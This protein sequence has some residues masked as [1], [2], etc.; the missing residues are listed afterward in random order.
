MVYFLPKEYKLPTCSTSHYLVSAQKLM[1]LMKRAHFSRNV[2]VLQTQSNALLTWYIADVFILR[3]ANLFRQ[4]LRLLTASRLILVFLDNQYR[5]SLCFENTSL[6][7]LLHLTMTDFQ[8]VRKSP[9]FQPG[10]FRGTLTM[11]FA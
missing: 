8:S 4:I 11:R 10:K 7:K 1:C 3:N 2:P 5:Q 9:N 6:F